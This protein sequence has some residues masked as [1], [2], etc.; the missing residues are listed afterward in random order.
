MWLNEVQQQPVNCAIAR[1]T[2]QIMDTVNDA[3]TRANQVPFRSWRIYPLLIREPLLTPWRL[4]SPKGHAY[5]PVKYE[6]LKSQITQYHKQE[7]IH[8]IC[9]KCLR[10]FK[11]IHNWV[12]H[13]PKCKGPPDTSLPYSCEHCELRF[14]S[15]SGLSTHERSKHPEV[16]NQKRMLQMKSKKTGGRKAYEWTQDEVNLLIERRRRF[17]NKRQINKEI[18]KFLSSTSCKQ[19]SDKRRRL[20]AN[21]TAQVE[22]SSSESEEEIYLSANEDEPQEMINISTTV[23]DNEWNS[24]ILDYIK[25]I[26]LP[27]G[28]KFE[29]ANI[30]LDAILTELNANEVI[31][32]NIK[33]KIEQFI[34]KTLKPVLIDVD[35]SSGNKNKSKNNRANKQKRNRMNTRQSSDP[36]STNHASRKRFAYARCQ[37]LFKKCPKRLADYAIKGDSSFMTDRSTLP[38]ASVV[39]QFY[40][41]LWEATNPQSNYMPIN[42]DRR[43]MMEVC[44]N[45]SVQDVIDRLKRTNFTSAA[46][47][48]GVKRIHLV[49]KE[50]YPRVWKINRTTLIPKVNSDLNNVKNWR[51]ITIGPIIAR[52]FSGILDKKLGQ[53]ININIRQKG[54]TREDG[55]RCNV[56]ILTDAIQVMKSV[57]GGVVTIV[58]I[59]KAFDTVPHQAILK[60][61]DRARVPS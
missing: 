12:C 40:K 52:I 42:S 36:H 5:W 57:N 1:N 54:F 15:Q 53:F 29:R 21:S 10:Q 6:D 34:D 47:T 50:Y 17:Q 7:L 11:G 13:Y 25:T 26:E 4:L 27:E 58:D 49:K 59:A 24:F 60:Q 2:K 46:G 18:Q 39:D 41:K 16:R 30:E 56:S 23:S 14:N 48:D 37:E 43:S 3:S 33:E 61:L 28:S 22:C 20:R 45:M 55:C 51:P 9:S 44:P 31:N 38:Q 19:I 32:V 35:T 8:Y